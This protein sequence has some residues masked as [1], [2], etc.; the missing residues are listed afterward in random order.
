MLLMSTQTALEEQ[1]RQGSEVGLA[2]NCKVS[3][4]LNIVT[5]AQMSLAIK[6]MRW[7]QHLP[8]FPH[9]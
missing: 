3:F 7:I 4:E 5:L 2:W 6:C 9:L 8:Q 1:K